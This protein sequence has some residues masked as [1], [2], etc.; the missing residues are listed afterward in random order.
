M[1]Q[2]TI[3]LQPSSIGIR[4]KTLTPTQTPTKIPQ[5]QSPIPTKLPALTPSIT[6][7][8]TL[9]MVPDVAEFPVSVKIDGVHGYAQSYP[10][11]CESRSAVDLAAFFGISINELGFQKN[12]PVSDDP[13]EG[14]V[15]DYKDPSGKTPPE[16]YGVHAPPVAKLL[17][18]YG[19]NAESAK[20]LTWEDIQREI[21]SGHPVMV[22]VVN[23]P[24]GE[25]ISYTSLNGNTTVVARFEHTVLITGYH[26]DYVYLQDGSHYYATTVNRFLKSWSILQFMAVRIGYPSIISDPFENKNSRYLRNSGS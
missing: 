12:L 8:E 9:E 7:T 14:F 19:L 2:P 6:T 3:S 18:Y 11:D 20:F 26:S 5:K 23:N 15:G 10:L 24:L 17:R 1:T 22:W 16:S 4:A 13:D 21:V 25:P